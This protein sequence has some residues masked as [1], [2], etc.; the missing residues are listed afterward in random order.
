MVINSIDVRKIL[1]LAA[2][3]AFRDLEND[4]IA[5][6]KVLEGAGVSLALIAANTPHV[7]FD[8]VA[9][10]ATVPLLSIVE[11]NLRSR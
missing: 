2:D 7:V 9:V 3:K 10:R 4:L 11:G 6:I 8:E 1:A 5:E